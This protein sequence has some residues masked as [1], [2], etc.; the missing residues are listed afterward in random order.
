[1]WSVIIRVINKIEKPRCLLSCMITD[2]I[3]RRE[4]FKINGHLVVL[5]SVSYRV[6]RKSFLHPPFGQAEASIYQPRCHFNQPPKRFVL[7]FFKFLM[8]HH[9][10]VGQV[11]NR[12]H[13]PDSKIHQ[14]WAIGQYFLCTLASRWFLSDQYNGGHPV[15]IYTLLI[16]TFFFSVSQKLF[17]PL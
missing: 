3:G 1:M 15:Y 8:K 13:Q 9:L 12:I 2:Q 5:V 7:L 10:P 14:L 4:V 16:C 17:R 11:K 6:Q